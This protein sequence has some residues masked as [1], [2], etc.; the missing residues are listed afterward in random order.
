MSFVAHVSSR[1]DVGFNQERPGKCLHMDDVTA[2]TAAVGGVVEL[3]A[4]DSRGKWQEDEL[5]VRSLKDDV[6][7]LT[8]VDRSDFTNRKNST[9]L[10]P[11]SLLGG[12][13][14]REMLATFRLAVMEF[15]LQET[16]IIDTITACGWKYFGNSLDLTRK[17]SSFF[18][19]CS[20]QLKPR[21]V[22]PLVIVFLSYALSSV[23]LHYLCSIN[24]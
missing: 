21:R 10:R 4:Y 7:H 16:A 18:T 8:L 12:A 20:K 3:G 1:D 15:K 9:S 22:R 23:F 14:E 11:S 2:L 24:K 13:H 6:L 17:E 19:S 5:F